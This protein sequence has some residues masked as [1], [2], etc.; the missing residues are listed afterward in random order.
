[1]VRPR[2]P[3]RALAVALSLLALAACGG[4]G[5]EP[6]SGRAG[7]ASSDGG[8]ID[9]EGEASA[10]SVTDWKGRSIEVPA[11]PA[12]VV[13]LDVASTMNLAL[14]GLDVVSAP[15]DM[16]PSFTEDF[17]RFVPAGTRIDDYEVIGIGE[18][19]NVEALAALRP[20]L[21]IGF[22][23]IE[24]EE[25]SAFDTLSQI[26]P[27]VLY[28][29]GT[30]ALW[31]QRFETEAAIVGRSDRVAELEDA[32]AE[33]TE[34]A[35]PYRNLSFAF[36]RYEIDGGGT[37]RF[38]NPG[39]S[40]PGSVLADAGGVLFDAPAGLGAL[41]DNGSFVPDIS[42]ERIE[43]LTSD[44]IVVQDLS[45]FGQD[46][47]VGLFESTNPLWTTLPAVKAGRVVTLP[48]LVFNGGTYASGIRTLE[49]IAEALG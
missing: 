11:E 12:R 14:L 39:T 5:T 46:D 18:S 35:A 31:R 44:V 48:G 19:L 16:T 24:K 38:E 34:L 41:N 2:P 45:Q 33:A 42:A 8:S 30:N 23:E 15:I 1:M 28:E 27:T 32:Y 25:P 13:A 10:R 43:V 22:N 21:I 29:F 17:R 36:I 47:P 9:V 7:R 3:G 26:A 37:W 40:V 20:D 4:G 6:E 49:L